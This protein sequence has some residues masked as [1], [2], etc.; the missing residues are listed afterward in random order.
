MN[1]P[2]FP[3]TP[4]ALILSGMLLTG[5]N[6]QAED[7]NEWG[8]WARGGPGARVVDTGDRLLL[9]SDASIVN[10]GLGGPTFD[11]DTGEPIIP[12]V[13]PPHPGD[14]VLYGMMNVYSDAYGGGIIDGGEHAVQGSL[15]LRP[16]EAEGGIGQIGVNL[17]SFVTAGADP[18]SAL[19]VGGQP[20]PLS[21]AAL[22]SEVTGP[23]ECIYG[24][25]DN[26]PMYENA[27]GFT[28][29]R[30]ITVN[31]YFGGNAEIEVVANLPGETGVGNSDW[32]RIHGYQVY[33]GGGILGPRELIDGP[34]PPEGVDFI[35]TGYMDF[36]GIWFDGGELSTSG[37]YIAGQPTFD[38][39]ALQAGNLPATYFGST[40]S[41]YTSYDVVVNIDFQPGTF[42][43]HFGGQGEK[44]YGADN[45]GEFSVAG[46]VNGANFTG[47]HTSS[48][49]PGWYGGVVDASVNG[50]L[51]GPNAEALGGTV[52]MDIDHDEFGPITKVDVFSAAQ[53]PIQFSG[54]RGDD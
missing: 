30:A 49:E 24:C 33:S 41:Y 39:G 44:F 31:P 5:A 53:E 11:P 27:P 22:G 37:N 18:W 10:E 4:I 54:G 23:E 26:G 14:W 38:I 28:P 25:Y 34:P 45:Y 8:R 19:P 48:G 17:E 29:F 47:Q 46:T 3:K 21:L 16:P 15:L 42:D 9:L 50:T 20:V 1:M 32:N 36:S 13:T 7:P 35:T 43:A 2:D 40:M 52:Q 6:V 51:F 12:P